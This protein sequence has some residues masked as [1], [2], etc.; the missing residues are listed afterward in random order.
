MKYIFQQIVVISLMAFVMSGCSS[1]Q[2][3]WIRSE[4][5]RAGIVRTAERYVGAPY[6]HGGASPRG[7]DCSGYVMY[8]YKKNGILLPRQVHRQYDAGRHISLR[9][10]KAGDLVFFRTSRSRRL[11][12]VG[13]YLGGNRFIHAPSSGKR[14]TYAS[15]SKPYWKRRYRGAVT[16]MGSG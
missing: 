14:V 15:M 7:F 16:F 2:H 4:G 10:A 11:S 1:Y 8:V 5:V 12:H 6:R 13:I 3:G 9:R